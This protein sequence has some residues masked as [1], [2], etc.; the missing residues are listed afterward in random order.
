MSAGIYAT[1]IKPT[2]KIFKTTYKVKFTVI[3]SRIQDNVLK[4][5][6]KNFEQDH[7]YVEQVS[8]QQLYVTEVTT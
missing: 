5:L 1:P 4:I 7:Q 3:D 2:N 6:E 8:M